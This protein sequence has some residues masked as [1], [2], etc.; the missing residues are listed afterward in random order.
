MLRIMKREVSDYAPALRDHMFVDIVDNHDGRWSADAPKIPNL[1]RIQV[2]DY[3]PAEGE[4]WDVDKWEAR[5]SCIYAPATRV[6]WKKAWEIVRT[7]ARQG[8][9]SIELQSGEV[10]TVSLSEDVFLSER[11]AV[12]A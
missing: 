3:E 8:W 1:L 10:F 7:L 11:G 9:C 12:N 5:Q 4:E 6:F 2:D